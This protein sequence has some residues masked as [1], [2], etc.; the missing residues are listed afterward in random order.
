VEATRLGHTTP[1]PLPPCF[2]P[3]CGTKEDPAEVGKQAE[4]LV[5]GAGPS[6]R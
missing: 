6:S 1:S 3:A 4:I 2:K 5:S